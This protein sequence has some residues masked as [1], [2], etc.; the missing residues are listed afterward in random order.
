[1]LTARQILAVT[2]V[3]L[4]ASVAYAAP[5]SS[6]VARQIDR[7]IASELEL[8][9]SEL[10]PRTGD[11]AFLRRTYLDLVGTI[12]SPEEVTRF[13]ASKEKDKRG[14]LVKNLLDRPRFGVTQAR[15]WRDVILSRRLEDRALLVSPQLVDDLTEWINTGR[16]WDAIAQEFITATGKVSDNGSTAIIVAQEGRTE[17]IAAE[18]SRVFLG[19]QIQ[20]AQCHDHPW[21][22]WKREQFH[23]LAAFF[24]RVGARQLPKEKGLNGK[25]KKG[26]PQFVVMANDRPDRPRF[27][28]MQNAN[29][30][31]RPNITCK[32]LSNL[33]SRASASLLVS[34]SPA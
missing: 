26:P 28:K 6:T 24:P 25:P 11:A 23:E 4:L 9:P 8:S 22:D 27:R 14:K 7:L 29:R 33:T 12:P 20:C 17:E 19:I 15:Y 10:A 30:R 34:S 31:G 1:M 21:D 2:T 16:G 18:V 3:A 5:H 13:V 32:T